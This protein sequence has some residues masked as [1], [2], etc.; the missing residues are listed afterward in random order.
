MA[1]TAA[2]PGAHESFSRCSRSHRQLAGERQKTDP[3][4]GE[5]LL[6]LTLAAGMESDA[7]SILRKAS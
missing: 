3:H 7:E 4:D 5:A 6:A 1:L 2:G